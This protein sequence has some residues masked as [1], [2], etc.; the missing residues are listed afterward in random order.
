MPPERNDEESFDAVVVGAGFGGS[1]FGGSVMAYRLAHA[2]LRV[3]LLERGKKWP[4]GSFPRTPFEFSQAFWDPSEGL[5]GL[6]DVWSFG[7]LN[8]L[9][10]SGLG[11]GSLIYANVILE[12][13][14]AWFAESEPDGG[15]HPWPISYEELAPHY[16]EVFPFLAPEEY[17]SRYRNATP[18]TH[19]FYA[20]A[21]LRGLQPFYPPLAVTFGE[22]QGT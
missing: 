11:G 15:T 4:P 6:L 8:A 7:G 18:K 22:Q 13:P 5:H 21:D 10:S 16:D 2:N 1:G 12:K 19:A 17:P 3:C 9:V 20:A 14:E